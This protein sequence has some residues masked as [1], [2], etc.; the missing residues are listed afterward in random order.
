MV[1][2]ENICTSN[3]IQTECVGLMYLKICMCMHKHAHIRT[4]TNMYTCMYIHATKIIEKGGHKSE[5]GKGVY[6]R[7][8][9]KKGRD[10]I[11]L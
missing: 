1:S 6:G 10:V 9:K 7:F 3:T 11:I 4:S 2:T 5:K 8:E